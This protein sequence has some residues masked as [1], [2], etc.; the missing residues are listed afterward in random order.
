MVGNLPP[1]DTLPPRRLNILSMTQSLRNPHEVRVVITGLGAITPIGN[2][3]AEYWDN[4][5]KGKS[6]VRRI[7]TFS[8]HDYSVQIAGEIDLPDV[9]LY[10]K[11]RKMARRLDRYVVLG[12]IAGTQ[13][14]SEE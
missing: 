14:R 12:Q 7:S 13:A 4:L 3:V 11:D 5:I 8:T 1:L 9:G 2:T 10:F 6:G